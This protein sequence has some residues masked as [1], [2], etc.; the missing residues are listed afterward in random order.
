MSLV[1]DAWT[2]ARKDLRSYFR[3]RTG[4]LLGFLLPIALVTA[5]GFIAQVLYG[6]QSAMGRTTLWF[7]DEDQSSGSESFV[8]LLRDSSTI[9]LR[10]RAGDEAIDAEELR[11]KVVDGDAH[12]GLIIPAGFGASMGSGELPE[13]RMVRDPDRSMEDQ[14]ISIGLM[15]AY[16][17][18]TEG[19]SFPAMM[20][21]QMEQLGMESEQAQGVVAA[22]EMI[23]GLIEVFVEEEE[24]E[25]AEEGATADAADAATA[26]TAADELEQ[27]FSM[28]TF[29]TSM[30]PVAHEDIPPPARPR[31]MGYMQA[32]SVAGMVVMMLMFGLVACGTSLI[33]EREGG[34]LPRLLAAPISRDA[35]L[36][37]KL[38]FTVIIGYVQLVVLFGYG[39]LL[40]GFGAFQ[41]PVTLAIL[42][43]SITAAVTGF[44]LLVATWARTQKQAEG[45]STLIILVMSCLGGAWFPLQLFDVPQVVEVI[46]R[47]TLVHWAMSGLQNM[48]FHQQDWTHPNILTSLAVLWGFAVVA[49]LLSRWLYFRR[50][51]LSK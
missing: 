33:V 9:A 10:P 4:M 6:G 46:M 22:A 38:I 24:A 39:E 13:L 49:I 30:V 18:A 15:Q 37:G 51:A 44:G 23:R 47:C 27:A 11:Q 31:Q 19:K 50:L 41:D 3:D 35:I 7:A 8:E 25:E 16:L 32:Q 2:I 43:I 28:D 17:G 12:H 14:M 34:T 26:S 5:F 40:F 21:R 1:R 20:G 36:L 29:M 45:V 48:F 42:M